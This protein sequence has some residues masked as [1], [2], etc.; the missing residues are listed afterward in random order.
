VKP[1]LAP[2][3]LGTLLLGRVRTT[4]V[5]AA[6]GAALTLVGMATVRDGTVFLT[7]VLPMLGDG[8]REVLQQYDKSLRG[9]V[10][11]L[12]L[13]DGVGLVARAGA[14]ALAVAVAWRRRRGPLAAAEVVPVLLLGGLLASSFSWANYSLYLLPLLVTVVRAGSLVRT[15]PAW[16][17]VFLLWTADPWP[18][19]ELGETVEAVVGLRTTWGWLLLL[20][21]CVWSAL[22][23]TSTSRRHAPTGRGPATDHDPGGTPVTAHA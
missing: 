4:C 9:A 2:L 20:A 13:P 21:A 18:A 14:L 11:L 8:N 23:P 3:L 15:W 5:A 7:D 10:E 17:A 6:V 16:A 22:R 19:L 12:G 1:T